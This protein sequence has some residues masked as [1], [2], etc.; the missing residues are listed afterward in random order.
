RGQSSLFGAL[1][2]ASMRFLPF[3]PP[4]P[5]LSVA[6]RLSEPESETRPQNWRHS[7]QIGLGVFR[8]AAAEAGPFVALMCCEKGAKGSPGRSVGRCVHVEWGHN[9]KRKWG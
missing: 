4:P 1:G 3:P 6:F 5:P 2:L 7:L 8:R 9:G